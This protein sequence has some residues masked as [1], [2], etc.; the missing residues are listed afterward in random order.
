MCIIGHHEVRHQARCE[1]LRE[2][3]AFAAEDPYTF[4]LDSCCQPMHVCVLSQ[5]FDGD[6]WIEVFDGPMMDKNQTM[7]V[8]NIYR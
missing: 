2:G 3:T 8:I 7:T 5:Y 6:L 1:G 4:L